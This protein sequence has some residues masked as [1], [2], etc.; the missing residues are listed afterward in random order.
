MAFQGR[1]IFIRAPDARLTSMFDLDGIFV[2]EAA[3]Q[4]VESEADNAGLW[5]PLGGWGDASIQQAR[6]TPGIGLPGVAFGPATLVDGRCDNS[7]QTAEYYVRIRKNG[8]QVHYHTSVVE[9]YSSVAI[10]AGLDTVNL[11]PAEYVDF[12]SGIL[13][14]EFFSDLFG[15]TTHRITGWL[16]VIGS[17]TNPPLNGTKALLA[18]TFY[19]KESGYYYLYHGH[20]EGIGA[21]GCKRL[22]IPIEGEE[23]GGAVM[24]NGLWRATLAPFP[25]I[26]YS[27]EANFVASFGQLPRIQWTS[28]ERI[29]GSGVS[30]YLTGTSAWTEFTRTR[31]PLPRQYGQRAV[32]V[33]GVVLDVQEQQHV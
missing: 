30:T 31:N 20:T 32:F 28:E 9:P 27:G 19:H 3:V 18:S 23:W 16:P 2:Y 10:F 15:P 29:G 8:I 13:R 26:P 1:E 21:M 22:P 12:E 24:T 6:V 11:G 7:N 17:P 5:V 4:V 33:D 14:G 25:T